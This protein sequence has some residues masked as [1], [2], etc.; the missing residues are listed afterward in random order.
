MF[1]D[2]YPSVHNDELGSVIGQFNGEPV[3]SY[4]AAASDERDI[5]DAFLRAQ[6]S[7]GFSI[8]AEVLPGELICEDNIIRRETAAAEREVIGIEEMLTSSGSKVSRTSLE[9]AQQMSDDGACIVWR[10]EG[11]AAG[12]EQY[13]LV[14]A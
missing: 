8:P 4:D 10:P 14:V 9:E 3:R 7:S 5:H 11:S 6:C 2:I 12:A 13:A 1:N